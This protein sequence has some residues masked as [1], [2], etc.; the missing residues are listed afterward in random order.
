MHITWNM[1]VRTTMK[2]SFGVGTS[3]GRS[4]FKYMDMLVNVGAWRHTHAHALPNKRKDHSLNK[5]Y[6]IENY[7]NTLQDNHV[8]Q[9]RDTVPTQG[10]KPCRRVVLR[11]IFTKTLFFSFFLFNVAC[12]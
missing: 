7:K 9:S 2:T 11:Q 6:R 5:Q 3:L 8:N 12:K 10:N 4:I 1:G